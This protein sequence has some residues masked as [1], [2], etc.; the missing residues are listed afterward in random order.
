MSQRIFALAIYLLRSFTLSLAGLLYLLFALVYYVIFFDPRQR[1]PD[2][3]YYILVLGLFGAVL[4]FLVTLSVAAKA[5]RA[6]HFPFLVRLPSRIEYLT[7]VMIASF[8]YT[9]IV[10][11]LVGV[12]AIVANGPHFSFVQLLDIPPIWIAGNVLLIVLALHASDLVASGWSRVYIFGVL[13]M[14]LYLRTGLGIIAD[15]L[16]GLFDQIGTAFQNR[17]WDTLADPIYGM[18]NWIVGAGSDLLQGLTGTIFWPFTTIADATVAGGFSLG[19][20]F[21]PAL[22]LLYATILFIIAAD[23]FADKDLFLTE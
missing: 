12:L 9:T 2:A 21:S 18:S 6:V 11:L 20:S 10:Q 17:G 1:T 5:N 3:D 8:I 22:I 4:A 13:A 23:L 14:L 16:S 7:A 19:Q 15:G